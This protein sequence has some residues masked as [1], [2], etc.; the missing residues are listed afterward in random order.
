MD[1]LSISFF[2]L[3]LFLSKIWVA[4]EKVFYRK[5]DFGELKQKVWHDGLKD[6]GTLLKLK[7]LINLKF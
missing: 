3:S 1:S 2:D 6:E 5:Y 4:H 7:C